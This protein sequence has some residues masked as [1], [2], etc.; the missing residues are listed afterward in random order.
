MK[1]RTIGTGDRTASIGRGSRWPDRRTETVLLMPA[2]DDGS[3]EFR[4]GPGRFRV[5]RESFLV[6]VRPLGKPDA[7]WSSWPPPSTKAPEGSDP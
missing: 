3:I 4:Y 2:H 7:Q 5:P 1:G 6:V